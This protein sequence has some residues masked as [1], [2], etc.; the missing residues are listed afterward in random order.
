[1]PAL[2]WYPEPE[3]NRH[4]H[5]WPLDFKSSASTYSAIRA[6]SRLIVI[7]PFLHKNLVTHSYQDGG[8][9]HPSGS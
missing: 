2:D 9:G 6:L 4:G 3:S 5:Y 8:T 7:Y 1:M